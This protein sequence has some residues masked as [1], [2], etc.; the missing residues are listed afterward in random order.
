M[1][2]PVERNVVSIS[3]KSAA[4]LLSFAVPQPKYLPTIRGWHSITT[5]WPRP[6]NWAYGR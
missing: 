2:N 4:P 1:P 5:R 6:K 3:R